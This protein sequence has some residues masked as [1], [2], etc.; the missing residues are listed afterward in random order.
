[1][2]SWKNRLAHNPVP[3]LLESGSAPV[4]FFTQRDL[5]DED[6][7]PVEPLWELP[8]ARKITRKQMKNGG[9]KYP[10][11]GASARSAE[12]Y[13]QLETYR[14]LGFLVEKFGFTRAHPAIQQAAAFLFSF[15]TAAGDFRGIYGTQYSPNYSAA[16]ME[17][18]IKAGYG[19]D[20]RIAR[21]L[22]WLLSI[23]QADGGW[24][25]PFRTAVAGKLD[26]A[27]MRSKTLEPDRARPFSHMITGVVLRAFAAGADFRGNA[28]V[29]RAGRLLALRFFKPDKYVDRRTPEFWT[30]FSFPF[31]FNDLLSALD[32]LSRL[33]FSAGDPDVRRGLDWFVERQRKDGGWALR[34]QKGK[35]KALPYWLDL[36]VCR[37]F[38]RFYS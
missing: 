14:N 7:G 26:D 38:K 37:V 15:Q 5:L 24:A 32:S 1:M 22:R 33:G 31:W 30:G 18:L 29:L 8:D 13:D 19:R 20:R 3:L 28:E 23:R 10:P 21:G 17:L 25:I 27:F 36:S 16:I 2:A 12:N 9:W 4:V 11:S 34:I 6:P 35:D